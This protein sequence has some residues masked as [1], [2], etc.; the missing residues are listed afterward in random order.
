MQAHK[1]TLYVVDLEG[2]GA[3]SVAETIENQK[4]PNYC[5]SPSVIGT[6]S[7][8]IGEWSDDHPLNKSDQ[9]QAEIQRLFG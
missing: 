7:A 2:M 5:I 8:D 9:W 3:Q 4:Y 6:E 1:I